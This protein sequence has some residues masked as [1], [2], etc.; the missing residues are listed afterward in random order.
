MIKTKQ[1]S[2]IVAAGVRVSG[3]SA[4]GASSNVTSALTTAL[5]S[6]GR[7]ATQVPLQPSVS[8]GLGL[9]TTSPLNIVQISLA[10]TG[11]KIAANNNEVYGRVTESGG[12]YTL[13]YF[14]S[15]N[16]TETAYSFPSA[17]VIDCDFNY[18]F[19]FARLPTDFAISVS[20]VIANDPKASLIGTS[21]TELLNVSA[22][23]TISSLTKTPNVPDNVSLIVNDA[24]Y[25]PLGGASARFTISGKAITW[26]N[27]NAGFNL[28]PG[29]FVIAKYTTNE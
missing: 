29:D 5:A 2:W 9:I 4:N 18:R 7:G 22:V 26:S 28:E 15:V 13:T 6:A 25:T 24:L 21:I 12:I 16:G 3:I 20:R 11:E 10:S 17:T 8:E 19:D 23:N 14:T 27:V 1:I